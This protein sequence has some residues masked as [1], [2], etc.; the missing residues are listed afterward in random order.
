M[1]QTRKY[2][3]IIIFPLDGVISVGEELSMILKMSAPTAPS[4]LIPARKR[5]GTSGREAT[6]R[7]NLQ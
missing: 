3:K 2:A 7:N 4:P 1:I 5:V 6:A